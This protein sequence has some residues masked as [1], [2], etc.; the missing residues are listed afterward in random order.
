MEKSAGSTKAKD[1]CAHQSKDFTQE[2]I[3]KVFGDK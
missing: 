3:R 1:S 2:K